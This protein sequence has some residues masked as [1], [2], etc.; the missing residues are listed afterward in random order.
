MAAI[1]P[2]GAAAAA[3]SHIGTCVAA[4]PIL[5]PTVVAA[6]V[7]GAISLGTFMVAGRRARQDRQRQLFADAF[8]MVSRYREFPFM[9][10]RRRADDRSR[11]S[12]DLSLVQAK[13][14][15]YRARLR[16]EAP[17]VG[18]IYAELVDATRR[19]AGAM[20]RDAW[21]TP[22]IETDEQIHSPGLDFS[23]LDPYEQRYLDA[24]SDHLGWL[25]P[26]LQ[27][28]LRERGHRT[29]RGP[30][31]PLRTGGTGPVEIGDPGGT[32]LT[33]EA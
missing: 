8:E 29:K 18:R 15:S 7:A 30:K 5:G 25:P 20:I 31:D 10:R 32:R 12:D 2:A 28:R 13:L 27:A 4:S 9:V 1:P 17:T 16:V 6:L 33:R 21:N 22:P 24:A 11:L 14:S 3:A 26:T 19:I 23:G